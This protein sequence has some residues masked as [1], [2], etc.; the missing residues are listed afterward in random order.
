MAKRL[1]AR[2]SA[3]LRER[4]D[5]HAEPFVSGQCRLWLGSKDG[6]GYGQIWWQG[7]LI[8]AHRAAW[9]VAH[10]PIPPG[11]DVLHRCDTPACINAWDCLFVGTPADN[12]ADMVAKGRN[13][14]GHQV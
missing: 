11:L 6:K 14:A 2:H 4:L 5:L 13:R 10:G 12:A 3:T 9:E 7:R 1:Y 8:P